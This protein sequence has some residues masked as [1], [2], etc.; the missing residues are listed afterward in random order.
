MFIFSSM[1]ELT[2]I[3]RK[4]QV[5]VVVNTCNPNILGAG[6]EMYGVQGHSGLLSV[7]FSEKKQ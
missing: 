2:R 7:T 5:G 4:Y 1:V 3:K 6:A